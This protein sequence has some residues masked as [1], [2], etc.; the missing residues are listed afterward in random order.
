MAFTTIPLEAYLKIH[1]KNNPN[2]SKKKVREKL[3]SAMKDH[4]NG[5]KCSCGEDIWILGSA[6]VGNSCFTCIT[7]EAFPEDDYEIEVA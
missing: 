1:L 5:I 7:G 3:R 2:E 4:N 6:F